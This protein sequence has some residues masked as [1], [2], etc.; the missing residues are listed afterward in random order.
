MKILD[1]NWQN[2]QNFKQLQ[3]I[4]TIVFVPLLPASK[5]FED[6]DYI[7][8]LIDK[9]DP[10]YKIW[11]FLINHYIRDDLLNTIS[12]EAASCFNSPERVNGYFRNYVWRL[13]QLFLGN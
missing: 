12:P 10:N 9:N 2:D 7:M 5:M 13:H 3:L 6:L 1:R 11:K 4:E 8:Q